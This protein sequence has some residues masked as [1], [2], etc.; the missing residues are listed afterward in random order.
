MLTKQPHAAYDLRNVLSWF[1]CVKRPRDTL[2]Y[3]SCKI[4]QR[5]PLQSNF[6]P[7]IETVSVFDHYSIIPCFSVILTVISRFL[8]LLLIIF[9]NQ[10]L[11]GFLCNHFL[12]LLYMMSHLLFQ[13]NH[14]CSEKRPKGTKIE[15]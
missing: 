5:K 2:V 7:I 3:H 13:Y 6:I 1:A 4:W 8:L 12:A 11:S 10:L 9:L 14:A 15:S